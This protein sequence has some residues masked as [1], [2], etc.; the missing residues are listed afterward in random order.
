M[1]TGS[2]GA[3]PRISKKGNDNQEDSLKPNDSGISLE[4]L[5]SKADGKL[6]IDE[7]SSLLDDVID[8]NGII[9]KNV[10]GVGNCVLGYNSKM[11]VTDILS[12]KDF[13]LN[14]A[15]NQLIL[16]YLVK[17]QPSNFSGSKS[18]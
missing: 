1:Q 5:E 10:D 7:K 9:T 4:C 14:V 17:F 18:L 2:K 3:S 6:G 12:V 8:S 16:F 13:V 15:Y 11:I